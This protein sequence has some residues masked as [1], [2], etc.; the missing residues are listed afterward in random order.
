MFVFL[1]Q[2]TYQTVAN[3][4]KYG[5]NMDAKNTILAWTNASAAKSLVGKNV[6]SNKVL[7]N[8]HVWKPVNWA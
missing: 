4:G 3:I 8:A 7:L 1:L 5:E 2:Y 6:K